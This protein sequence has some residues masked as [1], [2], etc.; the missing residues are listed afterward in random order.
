M[1]TWIRSVE[2]RITD[3]FEGHRSRT[4]PPSRNPGTD[5]GVPTGTPVKAI[6]DGTVT[7][8]IE[9]FRGAGGMMIFMS[10]PGGYN[11]DFLHLSRIDVVAGQE[12]K[13]GQVIGLSGGSGLGS[14]TGYGPHLHLSFRR[15][16]SPTMGV[17]NL[18]F[19]TYVSSPTPAKSVASTKAP[20]KAKAKAKAASKPKGK[21]K[22][23]TVVKNDNL[24]KIAKAH[25]TTVDALV[26]LNKIK[27]KNLIHIGQVL[28]V[29]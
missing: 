12:V 29:S 24:T 8:I 22:T 3:S 17:G 5:Y 26:K 7:G 28:K 19:E 15:G 6:A 2:G 21:A 23:Y 4:N 18:D 9:T 27:D 1:T 25:G 13:Q 16:G 11:A 14:M 20:A 10:F